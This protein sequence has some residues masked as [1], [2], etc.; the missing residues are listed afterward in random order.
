MPESSA[1]GSLVLM[2]HRVGSPLVRSI[3]RQQYAHPVVLRSQMKTLLSRGYRPL[4]L[5]AM[6]AQPETCYGHFAP[7]FDD[8]YA[9]V[10]RQG[11]PILAEYQVP[12]TI[13]MVAGALGKTNYWDEALGDRTEKM[14]TKDELRALADAGC[15]IGAHTMSHAHL[16][17]LSP[18]ELHAEIY[19]AKDL[20]ENLIGK[21]VRGFAYPYGE[22]DDRIRD[23]LIEAGYRYAVTCEQSAIYPQM[24][25]YALT[26]INMRWNTCGPVLTEK[27]DRLSRN[28]P[29]RND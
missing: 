13:F 19:D 5:G 20:L 12:A 14:L 6:L 15:E 11:F 10:W 7:T 25:P 22:F 29:P 1:S 24:D 21:P 17:G 16:L 23:A 2:Y 4:T 27:I 28:V 18:R 8:G 9:T 26:R 3:V